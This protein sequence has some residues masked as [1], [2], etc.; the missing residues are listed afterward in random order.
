MAPRDATIEQTPIA[1]DQRDRGT[2][3]NCVDLDMDMEVERAS[4]QIDL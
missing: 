4:G 1:A 3:G 2:R